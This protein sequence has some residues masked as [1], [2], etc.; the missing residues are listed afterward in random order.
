MSRFAFEFT[1][2]MPLRRFAT[3]YIGERATCET[4]DRAR[5]GWRSGGAAFPS[6]G[7]ER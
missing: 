2:Q 7:P 3:D 5:V 4:S 6:G 1:D